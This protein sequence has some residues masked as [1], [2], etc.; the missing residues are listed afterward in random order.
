MGLLYMCIDPQYK[1]SEVYLNFFRI[2]DLLH[3]ELLLVHD[4]HLKMLTV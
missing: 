3:L 4:I 1:K 2:L